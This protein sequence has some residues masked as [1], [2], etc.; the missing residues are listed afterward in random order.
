M[1][2]LLAKLWKDESGVT[3]IEYGLIAGLVGALLIVTLGALGERLEGI[4]GALNE[5]LEEVEDDIAA[6]PPDGTP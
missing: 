3:A 5:R 4:F 1:G 6:G 2:K